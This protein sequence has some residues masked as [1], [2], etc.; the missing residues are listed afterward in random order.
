[1]I[2]PLRATGGVTLSAPGGSRLLERAGTV[3]GRVRGE[4]ARLG[5][6]LSSAARE[7]VIKLGPDAPSH[8]C[9]DPGLASS[10]AW[11]ASHF[12]PTFPTDMCSIC[13]VGASGPVERNRK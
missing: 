1:M 7:V 2:G 4:V 12:R 5:A 6:R 13:A 9:D 11:T 10:D 8:D 3:V